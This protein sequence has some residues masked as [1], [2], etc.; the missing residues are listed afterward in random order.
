MIRP[1]THAFQPIV[2]TATKSIFAHEA[3]MRG[4]DNTSAHSILSG[5][6]EASHKWADRRSRTQ[7]I[8]LASSLGMT[9]SLSLNALPESLGDEIDQAASLG[10]HAA[11]SNFPLDRIIIEITEYQ[12]IADLKRFSDI[13][14]QY[15][16]L[17]IQLAIDDFG[18]GHSGLNLLADFQPDL[19]KLDMNLVRDIQSRGPRQSIVRAIIQVCEDLA[20]DVIAEGIETIDEYLWF[21]GNGV[22]LF[23][24]YL[25]ARPG[26]ESLPSVVFPN[27]VHAA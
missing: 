13:V 4:L 18:A 11:T 22:R 20:I 24:G 10:A 15:R 6:D 7:A 27:F 17:G 5:L 16:R 14:A 21:E 25:F 26:F 1:F 23:Q 3:L 19:I 12:V 8:A 2:D 9:S